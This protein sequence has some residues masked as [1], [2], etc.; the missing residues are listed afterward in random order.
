MTQVIF[1]KDKYISCLPDSIGV[2]GWKTVKG[3]VSTKLDEFNSIDY[4][5][6]EDIY[7]LFSALFWQDIFGDL[8]K[9]ENTRLKSF[10][11]RLRYKALVIRVGEIWTTYGLLVDE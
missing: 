2:D 3:L 9:N 1:D 4:E 6:A 8:I 7:K 10:S 11:T 5:S